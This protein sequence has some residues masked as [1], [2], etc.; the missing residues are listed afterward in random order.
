M[1]TPFLLIILGAVVLVA[2]SGLAIVNSACKSNHQSWCAPVQH[3]AKT[4]HPPATR[5]G[6]STNGSG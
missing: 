6:P 1:K 5:R 4:G 3:H 2:G